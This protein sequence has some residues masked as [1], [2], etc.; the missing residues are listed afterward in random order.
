MTDDKIN[1]VLLVDDNPATN[2]LNK[3]IIKDTG[4]ANNIHVA[5]NGKEAL[6]YIHNKA[7]FHDK[8][9]PKANIIFL[10]IN[11]PVMNGFEFLEHY[12]DLEEELKSGIILVFLT[13]SNWSKD[14]S[15][16]NTNGLIFDFIEKPLSEKK[17]KDICQ[18]YMDNKV[19]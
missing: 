8:V 4:M 1:C 3:K 11:M 13:T 16:A 9:Y 2:F 19:N 17:F 12:K 6:D 10:D 15:K 18:Y 14:K 7:K 5:L